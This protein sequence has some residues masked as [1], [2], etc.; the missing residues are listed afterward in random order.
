MGIDPSDPRLHAPLYGRI[1]MYNL[2]PSVHAGI[3]AAR[4]D[5]RRSLAR[6][7]RQRL[8]PGVRNRTAAWLRLPTL[9][10]PAIVC[11][12]QRDAPGHR[13]PILIGELLRSGLTRRS[14][15][16]QDPEFWIS[17]SAGTHHSR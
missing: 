6:K 17:V 15:V 4:T 2:G 7:R 16:H 5:G 1:D 8:F 14:Q 13:I 12:A 9:I 10:W 3:R 11:N